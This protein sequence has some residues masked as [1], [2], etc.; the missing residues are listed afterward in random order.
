MLDHELDGE[1]PSL[2]LNDVLFILFRHKWKIFLCATAGIAAAVAVYLLLP[3]LY[4]SQ[5]KLLVRYVVE[6]STVDALDNSVKTPGS[7]NMNLI[8][9]EVEILTS[10]DLVMQVAEA[11]GVERLL[12]GSSVKD[13]KAEAVRSILRNLHVTAVS[14]TNII[15]LSYKNTD[16]EL[17]V[18]VLKELVSRYFDKHLE[19]HRSATGAFDFVRKETD[20][21]RARLNQ[22]EKELEELEGQAG[23]I[24]PA[25]TTATLNAEL[26]KGEEELGAVTAEFAAQQAHVKEIEKGLAWARTDQ[27]D[28]NATLHVSSEAIQEYRALLGRL[29]HLRQTETELLSSYTS[30]NRILKARQAQIADLEKERRNLEEKYPGLVETDPAA[31]SSQSARRDLVSE[32]AQLLAIK[33]RKEALKSQLGDIRERLKKVA[34]IGPQLRELQ[35]RK[36]MEEANYKY[37]EASLE[38]ARVDETLDPSR[39]PNISVVQRPLT[40]EKYTKDK[41]TVVLG[42]ACGG[43]AFGVAIAFLIDLVLDRTVKRP[44]ELET[45]LSVPLL[46]SIPYFARNGH[47]RLRL[48]DAGHDSV[49][50]LQESAC[51]NIT[52]E[53]GDLLR[54][55]CEAIRDR[56]VFHFD[57]KG[58]THKPKLVAVTGLSKMAGASTLAAGLAATLVET[59]DKVLLV[60]KPFAPKRLLTDDSKRDFDYVIYDMPRLSDTSPTLAVAGFMD[61]VLLVVE[62]EKSDRD[63]VKRSY[64]QLA[65][66]NAKVSVIFNK[67]RDTRFR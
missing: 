25:E 21:L 12:R 13:M 4:E 49:T 30:T 43:L 11:V 38:K 42:L 32:N 64:T 47:S 16:P 15:S 2:K 9:S 51:P 14:E 7:E 50:A 65:A 40:A 20:Q 46:L 61:K 48:H 29:G 56:L 53:N 59:G 8:K 22:T 1:A 33:A 17:A 63:A 57:L 39:M 67:S 62:A 6:R 31:A 27:S 5:A 34:E 54:P 10:L 26:A 58:M 60:D 55:F 36:E 18:Q 24:S 35:R 41:K 19:V 44:L 37:F 45:R 28:K 23:I 66:A 3:P 52:L